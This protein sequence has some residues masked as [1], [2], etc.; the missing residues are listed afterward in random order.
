MKIIPMLLG[1]APIPELPSEKK[2][3]RLQEQ[4][5]SAIERQEIIVRALASDDLC[6][7]EICDDH[8]PDVHS[9][10]VR[11]DLAVLRNQGKVRMYRI[12][13][14]IYYTLMNA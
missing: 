8:L 9:K 11:K 4:A 3:H 6:S 12:G 2:K 10:T 1:L 7:A 13:E 14:S 5:M